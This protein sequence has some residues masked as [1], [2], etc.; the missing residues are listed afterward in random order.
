VELAAL[1]QIPKPEFMVLLLTGRRKGKVEVKARK[2][3]E[4]KK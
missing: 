4:R 3:R 1:L 2:K